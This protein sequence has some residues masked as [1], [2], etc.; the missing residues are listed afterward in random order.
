MPGACRGRWWRSWLDGWREAAGCRGLAQ[1]G[2]GAKAAMIAIAMNN[3]KNH[4]H[5][6]CWISLDIFVNAD[7]NRQQE[8]LSRT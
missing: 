1:A 5:L 2:S 6:N 7:N 8:A 4:S 3:N